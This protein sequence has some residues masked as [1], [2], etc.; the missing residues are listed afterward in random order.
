MNPQRRAICAGLVA[1]CC[2]LT[3]A[4]ASPGG[5]Y[6][7]KGRQR[8]FLTIYSTT[9]TNVFRH[10]ILDYQ[11][12][13]PGVT[14]RYLDI[15]AGRLYE[16]YLREAGEGRPQADV[17]LSSAMDLQVKLVNDGF[18]MPHISETAMALPS[19]AR[20]RNEA[21]GFTFEPAIMAFNRKAM[22]GKRV[23]QTR[24]ELV[25]AIRADPAFWRG[26]IGTYDVS[27][28]SVGYLLA[29]QDFRSSSD[30][31]ALVESFAESEVVIEEH[32][33][34]LL[35]RIQSGRLVAGYNLLGSYARAQPGIE[36]SLALVYPRDHTLV[37]SRTAIIARN[38]PHP[39][40]AHDFLEY[41]L[42][43]RGQRVL[44][45]R[46]SL[47]P[48]R[49]DAD[50]ASDRLGVDPSEIGILRP[51]PLGPGL[52]VYLDQHKRRRILE[53]WRGVLGRAGQ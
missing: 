28:S 34:T 21:F 17:L 19:W 13:R 16:R 53:S 47:P 30:F 50:T 32:T 23:P 42:S 20:W 39:E 22:Q 15:E 4:L 29:A 36:K 24:A 26:R 45:S 8:E 11:Q 49:G 1:A 14:V 3:P 12:T 46:S 9:D 40:L 31:G 5:V 7:A 43:P 48:I 6:P 25:D 27:R 2:G 37:L 10:V 38:A 18:A 41:L 52:L 51:I 44:A 35:E 33:S